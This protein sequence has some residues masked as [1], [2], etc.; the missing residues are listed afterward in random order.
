MHRMT[1]LNWRLGKLARTSG[2]LGPACTNFGAAS[3]YTRSRPAGP[4]AVYLGWAGPVAGAHLRN[5]YNSAP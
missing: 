3:A 1:W 5:F 2:S 4:P